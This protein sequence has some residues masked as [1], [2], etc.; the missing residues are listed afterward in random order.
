LPRSETC[1]YQA[2]S[3][4]LLFF[5][6][7]CSTIIRAEGTNAAG[8]IVDL[9]GAMMLDRAVRLYHHAVN[10][11]EDEELPHKTRHDEI[12]FSVKLGNVFQ[13]TIRKE[14]CRRLGS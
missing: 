8:S 11:S 4:E 1:T 2:M 7:L 3:F 10:G 13:I 12:A 6:F 9:D 14:K 5:L